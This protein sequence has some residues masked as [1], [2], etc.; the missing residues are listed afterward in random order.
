MNIYKRILL[1]TNKRKRMTGAHVVITHLYNYLLL[2]NRWI[3]GIHNNQPEPITA[4]T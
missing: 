2:Y 1:Q 3:S 4:S